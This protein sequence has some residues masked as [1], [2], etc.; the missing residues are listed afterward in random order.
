MTLQEWLNLYEKKTK[1]K[2][3]SE[4]GFCL[5]FNSEKG[6]ARIKIDKDLKTVMVKETCGD[7]KF[8]YGFAKEVA[9][10]ND[11]DKLA[12]F[13]CR[14]IHA[15]IRLFG[16]TVESEEDGIIKGTKDGKPFEIYPYNKTTHFVVQYL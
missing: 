6:F 4:D 7:G 3:G 8:W 15:Y 1:E 12:T 9:K 16:G 13:V 10:M 14:D 2:A 11:L 5:F